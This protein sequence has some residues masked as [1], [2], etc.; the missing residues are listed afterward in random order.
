MK[1][2]FLSFK[3]QIPFFIF[4]D[5]ITKLIFSSRDFF[6][7]PIHFHLVKNYGLAFSLN[8]GLL[9]NLI[10]IILGLGFFVYYYFQ[11]RKEFS[12]RGQLVFI[13]IFAGA[14]SNIIDRLY[15]GFVRDFLDLGLGFTFNLA[16][17]FVA[18][19]LILILFLQTGKSGSLED[20]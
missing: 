1:N 7:G 10:L 3:F 14:V 12:W 5:Q 20:F 6:V 16:D 9:P 8:F 19:G 17:A 11:H 13:F 2:E 4:L 15:L 18:I